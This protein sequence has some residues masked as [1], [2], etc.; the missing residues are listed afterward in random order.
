MQL[1]HSW[2]LPSS[3]KPIVIIGA[4]GIVND[5]HMPAY[6]KA[7]FDVLGVY[8]IDQQTVQNTAK[9]WSLIVY[10]SLNEAI[11]DAGKFN[12]VFDL[13]TPPSAIQG[14][15]K[16]I[17]VGSTV[18]IQK[19]MGADL[20]DAKGIRTI[21]RHRRLVAAV[22]FQLRFSPM[23]MIVRDSLEKK[24]I[25]GITDFEVH[26]NLLTPWELFPF[27]KEM[28]RVEIAV[29]SIHYLDLIRSYLGNPS[30]VWAQTLGHPSTQEFAQTRTSAILNYGPDIRCSL[31]INHNYSKGPNFQSAQIRIDG[32]EGAVM[33]KLGLLLDYPKGE[34]DEVWIYPKGESSWTKMNFEGGWFPEAF[35]GTMSNLQ[36]FESGEDKILQT[37]VEDAYHTMSLVEGCSLSSKN[38][39]TPLPR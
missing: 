6:R 5:A 13:A 32:I 7:N 36:R 3:P 8:D 29:H 18:L 26:L 24:L 4:G 21:C 28:S 23:M 39:G 16:Q 27:L 9:K 11:T 15:L 2:P 20:K 10:S 38:G 35:I 17:P 14:I 33:I 30:G 25:G 12:A 19:P 22:N 34:P 31:S 1:Q 37:S